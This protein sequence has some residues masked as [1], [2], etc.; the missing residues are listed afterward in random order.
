[1]I[2]K[3]EQPIGVAGQRVLGVLLVLHLA[4]AVWYVVTVSSDLVA[5]RTLTD[6]LWPTVAIIAA[7]PW[8]VRLAMLLLSG[9]MGGR[10]LLPPQGLI[11]I[12]LVL[13]G[14]TLWFAKNGAD[15]ADRQGRRAVAGGLLVAT[16]SIVVGVFRWRSARSVPNEELKPTASPSS[17]VE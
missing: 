10:R 16:M 15:I 14:G 13:F 2:E 11:L 9:R 1:M 4:W 6:P 7:F 3:Y 17:L 8:L 5:G 12:G